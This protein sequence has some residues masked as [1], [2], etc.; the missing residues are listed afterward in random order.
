VWDNVQAS[1]HFCPYAH[2][3]EVEHCAIFDALFL[4]KA[5]QAKLLEMG[6]HVFWAERRQL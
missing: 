6:D 2:H 1:D 3:Q 4:L 5:L